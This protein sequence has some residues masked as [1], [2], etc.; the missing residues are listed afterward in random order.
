[1]SS[2]TAAA[3]TPADSQDWDE[4]VA[5][6]RN[7]LFQ[8]MRP[9]MD[10]HAD[11]F[12]DGSI[13]VREG[14]EI[15][16]LLPASRHDDLLVSHGG[17][18]FGGLILGRSSATLKTGEIFQAIL[19]HASASGVGRIHYKAIPGLF[20]RLPAE[21]DLYFLQQLGARL[22]RRDLSTAV[23]PFDQV[24]LRK[25]RKYML[26]RARKIGDL[27]MGESDDWASFWDL[28]TQRLDEAH[29]VRPVHTLEEIRLLKDRFPDRIQLL[30]ARS[31]GE[32]HAGVVM[33]RFDR[34]DHTQYMATNAFSRDNGLLDALVHD[35]IQRAASEGKWLS[36]GVSTEDQGR[37][38]NAGLLDYKES[39]GGRC[40]VHDHYELRVA[41]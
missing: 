1:M 23:S 22:I 21:E 36:F 24:K 16:A 7:G 6:A 28:L 11:R 19:N 26:S 15:V 2:I 4:F 29:G 5:Q 3:Y 13:V 34:A 12:M 32:I 20:H 38:I 39:F 31:G 33:F 18:T 35:A 40:I 9:Y 10:Y 37:K 17:L 25:G 14:E 30:T 8:F 41:G 27:E